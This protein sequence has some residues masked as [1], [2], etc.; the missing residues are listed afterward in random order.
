MLFTPRRGI[1]LRSV[2][3]FDLIFRILHGEHVRVSTFRIDPIVW[4]D[5][6]VGSKRGD[7]VVDDF[8]LRKAEEPGL[9]AIDIQFE[10]G[11]I[12]VLGNEDIADADFSARTG[13]ANFV[14]TP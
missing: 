5:H 11:V 9:L 6:A 1:C 3:D 7:H 14:A 12:N 10:R 8:F 13:S 2:K 4:G